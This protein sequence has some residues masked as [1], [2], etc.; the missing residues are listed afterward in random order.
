MYERN[1]MKTCVAKPD[2]INR[3]N[4]EIVVLVR[5]GVLQERMM[6]RY[7]TTQKSAKTMPAKRYQENR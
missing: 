3:R 7:E 1:L 6:I 2:Q 4:I 5:L